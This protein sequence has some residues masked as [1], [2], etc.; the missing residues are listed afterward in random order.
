VKVYIAMHL[1]RGE[2][3]PLG[4]IPHAFSVEENAW[5]ALETAFG[6]DPFKQAVV[7]VDEEQYMAGLQGWIKCCT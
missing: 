3:V 2:W 7:S 6:H 5:K 4:E 1:S